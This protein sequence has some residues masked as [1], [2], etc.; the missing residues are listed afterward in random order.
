MLNYEPIKTN[1]RFKIKLLKKLFQRAITT[2][3]CGA[4]I[5]F[6]ALFFLVRCTGESDTSIAQETKP[7]VVVTCDPELDDLNSLIRFLLYSTDFDVEGLVYASSQYH[8]KG[9]GKGTKWFVEGREYSRN[10]LNYGPMESW[11]WADDE[12]FIHDAVEAYEKVYPNLKVHDPDYPTPEYLKSI[13][14]WG[15]IEFDGDISKDT[16]GS[17]LIKSLMLD[18][19]PGPLFITAWGGGS[20]IA[21]ALKSI[22]DTYEGTPEWNSVYKKVSE[23]VV[24]S[25]SGDQDDTYANYVKPNWPEIETLQTSGGNIGLA[26]NIQAS[27]KPE[28]AFYYE[29]EWVEENI[30]SKGSL[31]EMFRVWGDGK[32]MVEG[33]LFDYFGFSGYT[34]E[35]LKAMGYVVWTPVHTKGSWLA[36]GDT[37]TFLNFIANGLNAWEDQAWGG[38]SGRKRFDVEPVDYTALMADSVAMAEFMKQRRSSD[39]PDFIPAAQNGLAARFHWSVTPIYEDANHDPVI[40]GLS[41]ISAKP[42]ETITLEAN[43]SDP[44]GDNVSVSWH[45]FIVDPYDG[46]VST[47]NPNSPITTL[48]VPEDAKSGDNFHMVLEAVDSGSPALT[49]Y[50]RIIITVI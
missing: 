32:Q 3:L 41:N 45:Q 15:N 30:S 37:G 21:R 40:E 38:W 29:P 8:W 5:G 11:R 25:L 46:K 47:D 9:D 35:E 36:E 24:L 49:R 27:V 7:R 16:E 4:F 19:E 26:Y 12:R 23:K 14:H 42:G 34:D 44:D 6:A 33:D 2:G 1:M 13:I 10:G 28:Y 50:H 48:L 31:G 18:D 20:T 17:D 22:Q 43:V 39:F